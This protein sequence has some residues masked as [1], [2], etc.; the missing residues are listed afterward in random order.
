MQVLAP[1]L[2]ALVGDALRHYA[3]HRETR[4]GGVAAGGERLVSRTKEAGF[5]EAALRLGEHDV[6]RNETLVSGVVALEEGDHRA[7]AG[8]DIVAARDAPGLHGVRRGF[9]RV[10][11]VRHAADD[12]ILVGLLGQKRQQ[13]ADA[14]AAD[15]GGERGLQRS[16]IVVA[17][18]GFGVEGIEVGRAAPHPDL[19]DGLCFCLGR[20]GDQ[21]RGGAAP[22]EQAEGAEEAAAQ[23]FAPVDRIPSMPE[24][25]V[26]LIYASLVAVEKLRAVH[27]RPRQID[28]GF[29]RLNVSACAYAP[30]VLSSSSVGKR[31]RII[32]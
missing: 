13:F 16:A 28:H 26:S 23:R 17:G 8:V 21:G 2:L 20:R 31:E 11:A 3:F 7:H 6:G 5:A 25:F 22:S 32:R 18:L 9:V 30:T 29:A 27:Q 12:G 1:I 24:R 14:N 15:V 4:L 19:D 10:D